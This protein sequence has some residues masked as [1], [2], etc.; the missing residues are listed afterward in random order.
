VTV[1]AATAI[2]I[3]GFKNFFDFGFR[4]T[5]TATAEQLL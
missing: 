4:G 5:D 3:C 1:D 2:F